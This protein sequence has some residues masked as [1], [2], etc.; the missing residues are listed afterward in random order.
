MKLNNEKGFTL[1]ELMV[2]I[3]LMSMSLTA[4]YSVYHVQ[5]R[6]LKVQENRME[7]QVYARSVLDTMVREI[8]SAGYFPDAACTSPSNVG[9]IVAADDQTLQFVYDADADNACASA[10]ENIT[11][12]FDTASKNITRS[13]DGGAAQELTDGNTSAFQFTYYPRQTSGVSPAPFCVI[14]SFP[15]GCTGDLASNLANVY[16]VKIQLTVQSKNPDPEFGGQLLATMTSNVD[17][18]NRI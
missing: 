8:R 17:L 5:T 2:A 9:G 3:V 4:F 10:N 14:P 1:T 11:Y 16:R 18:R 15:T 12:A 13:A 7:A 6:S